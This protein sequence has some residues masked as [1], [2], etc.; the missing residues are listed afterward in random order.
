MEAAAQ[1]RTRRLIPAFDR[2]VGV[3]WSGATG[4]NYSGIAVAECRTGAAP[5]V[6]VAPPGRNWRRTDFVD[7]MAAQAGQGNRLLVGIDCA[8]ALPA[9]M[10][11]RV[12]GEDYSAAALWAHIDA[13]CAAA[14]D[15]FGGPFAEHAAHQAHFWHRGPR[16]TGFAEHHRATEHA[17]KAAGLGSPESPLKLVGARQVGKGGLAGMRVLHALKTRLG[18]SFAVWPFDPPDK[19]DIVC[20]ELYPRL[21]MKMVGHGNGK[22]R[23]A[24]ALNNCLVKLGSV[25]I[26]PTQPSPIK[27][28]GSNPHVPPPRWGR[29]GGGDAGADHNSLLSDHETDALVAAAG[30]RFVAEDR[31]VWSPPG[32]DAL[33]L[34]AEGWIFGVTTGG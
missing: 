24:E 13:T 17:C 25:P 12:L 15:F 3:D 7:W 30:L 18:E 29:R 34:R 21:F 31:A 6:L 20:I 2:F 9:A 28:E 23:T 26:T 33:A 8:F 19:A 16:P 4:R 1:R 5:R 11:G 14:G 27:G 10:A 22:V 32:M